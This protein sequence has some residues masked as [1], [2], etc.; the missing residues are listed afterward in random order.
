VPGRAHLQSHKKRVDRRTAAGPSHT[1]RGGTS[2]HDSQPQIQHTSPKTCK[3]TLQDE[4]GDST[5]D[6]RLEVLFLPTPTAQTLKHDQRL[7][8]PMKPVQ[9]VGPLKLEGRGGFG[10]V[11]EQLDGSGVVVRVEVEEEKGLEC[12]EGGGVQVENWFGSAHDLPSTSTNT[13]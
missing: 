7:L 8:L 5:H 4:D 12:G 11:G 3:A 13:R 9:A 1:L 2:G 10:R 6:L